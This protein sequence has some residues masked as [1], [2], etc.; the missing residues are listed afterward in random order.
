M[1]RGNNNVR[2]PEAGGACWAETTSKRRNATAQ[3]SATANQK[4]L[5]SMMGF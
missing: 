3:R 1:R 2:A 4:R 5:E